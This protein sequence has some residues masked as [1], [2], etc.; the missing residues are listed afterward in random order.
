MGISR[1][2]FLGKQFL[3]CIMESPLEFG[4]C[5]TIIPPIYCLML[6]CWNTG[7]ERDSSIVAVL[8]GVYE[9][10]TRESRIVFKRV[11]VNMT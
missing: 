6:I 11:R 3:E 7:I 5:E 9:I 4:E 10:R 8:T 1:V 2:N